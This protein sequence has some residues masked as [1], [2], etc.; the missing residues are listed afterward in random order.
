MD[1]EIAIVLYHHISNDL[2]R[3]TDLLDVST[4][5]EVFE[6]HIRYLSKHFDLIGPD[7]LLKGKLP[8]RAL[9]V[10]FDDAYRSVLDVGGPILASVNAPSI[11]FLNPATIM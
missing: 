1:K 8:R 6:K 9:L 10:T 5:P 2:D 11:F 3:L 7:D 4:A